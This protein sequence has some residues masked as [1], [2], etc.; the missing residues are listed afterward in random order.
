[1]DLLAEARAR[2]LWQSGKIEE[3]T[4]EFERIVT[5]YESQPHLAEYGHLLTLLWAAEKIPSLRPRVE[6]LDALLNE[7]FLRS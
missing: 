2:C 7:R 6:K 4:A 1:M 5:R 3:A